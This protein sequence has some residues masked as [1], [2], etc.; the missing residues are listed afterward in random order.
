MPLLSKASNVV[1]NNYFSCTTLLALLK[2]AI[3]FL[4]QPAVY[5]GFLDQAAFTRS[6]RTE[7]CTNRGW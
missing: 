1:Q 2:F 3:R 6:C 7:R 5:C 4:S